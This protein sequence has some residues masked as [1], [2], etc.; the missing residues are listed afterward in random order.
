MDTKCYALGVLALALVICAV[1][2]GQLLP[3]TGA[4]VV[5][6]EFIVA[7]K[8]KAGLRG[9]SSVLEDVDM[10]PGATF[11]REYKVCNGSQIHSGQYVS[12]T[13]IYVLIILFAL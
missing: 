12:T 8:S 11:L 13:N 2:C 3:S 4:Q 7:L 6:N 1:Q 10:I 9:S 5:P